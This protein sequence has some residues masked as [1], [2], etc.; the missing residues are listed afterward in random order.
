MI[1]TFAALFIIIFAIIPGIL[2]NNIYELI[3]GSKWEEQ[4]WDRV[5]RIISFSFLGL[6]LYILVFVRYFNFPIPLYLIPETYSTPSY[7]QTQIIQT[8]QV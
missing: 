8:A 5:V 7:E 6:V 1:D 3:V 2:G 4:L